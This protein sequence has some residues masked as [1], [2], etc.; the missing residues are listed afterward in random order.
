MNKL[1]DFYRQ[2]QSNKALMNDLQAAND[3]HAGPNDGGEW[4]VVDEVIGIAAHHGITLSRVD[5][6]HGL[7]DQEGPTGEYLGRPTA[8]SSAWKM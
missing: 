3:R 5:F 2:A 8:T 7:E 6:E 1:A 4:S